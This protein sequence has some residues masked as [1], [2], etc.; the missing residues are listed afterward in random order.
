MEVTSAFQWGL[1]V[2]LFMAAVF[3]GWMHE[4]SR[5]SYNELL[6]KYYQQRD[7]LKKHGI[8]VPSEDV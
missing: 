2:G 1:C 8:S 7:E 5:R 6:K 4:A 3:V